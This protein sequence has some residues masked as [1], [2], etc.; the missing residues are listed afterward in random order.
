MLSARRSPPPSSLIPQGASTP[1]PALRARIPV[2]EAGVLVIGA[3][4]PLALQDYALAFGARVLILAL[5]AL[6]FDLLWGYAGIMSFG[7][8]V[9]FGAAGYA[10][11]LLARDAQ[12]T[13]LF[14]VLPLS[15]LVGL[16]VALVLGAFLFLGSR[17]VSPVFVA[18]GTLA[19]GYV[20]DRLARNW[21]YVGAQNGLP[22]IP[23]L[24]VGATPLT[25]A[26]YYYL[27]FG[28]LI[29]VYLLCRTLVRSPFGLALAGL[30]ENEARIAFF[31]YRASPLKGVIFAVSGAIAGLAGGLYAFHEGFMWPGTLGVLMSTQIVMYVLLGGSGT[32]IG[33]ILGTIA[34]EGLSYWL[35]DAMPRAWPV[36]LGALLLVVVLFRPAG[37]VSLFVSERERVGRFGARAAGRRR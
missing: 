23:P 21:Q 30:R 10:A 19:A 1:S 17:R 3:L 4:L 26:G 33:A 12:I 37:L 36:L 27:A 25:E 6:S 16:L 5:L 31:G 29:V 9:F 2:L 14:I 20:A 11:G 34:L 15:L 32:L 22:S 13:S 7:Q 24:T 8:A 28:V 35:A 18:L